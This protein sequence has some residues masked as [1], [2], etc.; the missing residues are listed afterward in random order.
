MGDIR[1]FFA[2][3]IDWLVYL[4]RMSSLRDQDESDV[5]REKKLFGPTGKPSPGF[6]P[7]VLVMVFQYT[8]LKWGCIGVAASFMY[9]KVFRWIGLPFWLACPLGLILGGGGAAGAVEQ[10]YAGYTKKP[11]GTRTTTA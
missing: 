10:R 3:T 6:L 11:E 7:C 4:E 5:A 9:F 8:V 1:S 2:G